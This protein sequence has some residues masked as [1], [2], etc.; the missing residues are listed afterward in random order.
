MMGKGSSR[1]K[2]VFMSSPI[3]DP[4][5]YAISSFFWKHHP[6]LKGLLL[7]L[8]DRLS[9]GA[10]KLGSNLC[11]KTD[12]RDTSWGWANFYLK[13]V[14]FYCCFGRLQVSCREGSFTHTVWTGI[15]IYEATF[16]P[17]RFWNQ[18]IYSLDSNI[19]LPPHAKS[20]V[21]SITWTD[22]K[23]GY[24]GHYWVHC[25]RDIRH[26]VSILVAKSRVPAIC[27]KAMPIINQRRRRKLLANEGVCGFWSISFLVL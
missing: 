25:K 26:P 3:N 18:S 11:F 27:L 9:S 23:S 22:Q 13:V 8:L 19:D 6:F 14:T 7:T 15:Q 2:G 20:L 12:L 10:R 5:W 1:V 21:S 24:P 4:E 16:Q 17:F